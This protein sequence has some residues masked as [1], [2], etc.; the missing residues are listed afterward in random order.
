MK[1]NWPDMKRNSMKRWMLIGLILCAGKNE[2]HVELL[3]LHN[4][5]IRVADYLTVLPPREVL[6]AKLHQSI[7]LARQRLL[8]DKDGVDKES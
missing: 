7:E 4:S 3:Q 6:Q 2:E 8:Q 5:N 1:E